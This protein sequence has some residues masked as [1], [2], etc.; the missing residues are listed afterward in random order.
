MVQKA[1]MS[2]AIHDVVETVSLMCVPSP[3]Y[4][5]VT[6]LLQRGVQALRSGLTG[7]LEPG[8]HNTGLQQAPS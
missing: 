1:V 3:A 5:Q 8:T 7:T 2:P 4:R 6:D